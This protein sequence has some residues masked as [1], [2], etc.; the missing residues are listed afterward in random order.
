[1]RDLEMKHPHSPLHAVSA[2]RAREAGRPVRG[3]W[4][5][6]V[7]EAFYELQRRQALKVIGAYQ[8]LLGEPED[9]AMRANGAEERGDA[10]G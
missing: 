2:S 7:L 10:D 5:A 1:M 6:V 9:I 4:I 3:N 8:H